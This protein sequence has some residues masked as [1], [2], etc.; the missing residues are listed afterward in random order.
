MSATASTCISITIVSSFTLITICS[1][2][3]SLTNTF[4]II[5]VLSTGVCET[6]YKGTDCNQCETGYY[7][8]GNTCTSCGTHKTTTES[9]SATTADQCKLTLI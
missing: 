6:G 8:D 7:G 5:F 1:F 9:G 3:T 2:V 4:S